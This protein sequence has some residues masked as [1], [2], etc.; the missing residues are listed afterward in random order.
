[1]ANREVYT[2][3]KAD[4]AAFCALQSKG[5][6]G[7]LLLNGTLAGQPPVLGISLPDIARVVSITSTNDLSAVNFTITGVLNNAVVTVTH[8]GPNNSTYETT[9]LFN[10]VTSVTVDAAAAAVKVGTGSTGQSSYFLFDFENKCANTT[11]QAIATA[12][13]SY[14]WGVTLD[15][16]NT[17]ASPTL[18][19]PVSTLLSATGSI[20][21]NYSAPYVA[22]C[23]V[24]ASSSGNG[25]VTCTTIQQGLTS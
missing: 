5:A 3:P 25:A 11:I 13:I 22:A 12:T 7:S 1:M 8:A 16:P 23:I 17:V 19:Y 4:T 2:W 20:L 10:T 15:N 14:S 24:V 18:F 9:Q 21:A 6:A